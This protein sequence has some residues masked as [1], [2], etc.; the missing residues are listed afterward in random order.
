MAVFM[1]IADSH[2]HIYP[3]ALASRALRQ[4]ASF[5][6]FQDRMDEPGCVGTVGYL[7]ECCGQNGVSV[8]LV[9]E[10]AH[11][12]SLVDTLN[13]FILES[14]AAS[15]GRL[16][17][18]C[19]IHPDGAHLQESLS[20]SKER[21]LRGVK[22][23]PDYQGFD[24][25]DPKCDPIYD[26]CRL[27][28]FPLLIHC[29]DD[30]Y[31][32]SS[33]QRLERVLKRFPG[34]PVIAAHFGGFRRWEESI[35]LKPA[36]NLYFDTSSS[37]FSISREQALRFFE[38]FS[39]ERFFFGSDYPLFDQKGELARFFSLRLPERQSEAILYQNFAR[40]FSL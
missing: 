28:Q 13:T 35:K 34:L 33:P 25:D 5:Y 1:Q 36:E 4:I 17:G 23:H 20:L 11:K 27:E 29:G 9:S 22:I 7:L 15:Q 30:R 18:L 14:C 16:I 8:A 19:A 37:L 12:P 24:L 39:Y 40:F 2:T 3:D 10:A 6:G 21:G 32:C 38:K 31:D 26:F